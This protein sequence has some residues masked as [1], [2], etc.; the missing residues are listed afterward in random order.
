MF[1][2]IMMIYSVYSRIRLIE[3][4]PKENNRLIGTNIG[5]VPNECYFHFRQFN[6]V[7]GDKS[8]LVRD[9]DKTVWLDI[10]T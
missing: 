8:L 7:F 5:I 4:P 1:Q 2:I 6:F 9:N 3:T 10:V